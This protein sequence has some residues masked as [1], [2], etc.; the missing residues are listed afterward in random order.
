MIDT[1]TGE[2]WAF[3]FILLAALFS[4]A[5]T[6]LATSDAVRQH[7]R[8]EE[9]A[10][11][12]EADDRR[13]KRQNRR[14]SVER[15]L[16]EA[17]RPRLDQKRFQ[18][19]FWS[20]PLQHI[21]LPALHAAIQSAEQVQEEVGIS[22]EVIDA[23]CQ[24]MHNA[25]QLQAQAALRCG[26]AEVQLNGILES[27]RCLLK[28]DTAALDAALDEAKLAGVPRSLLDRAVETLQRATR[29]QRKRDL[30]LERLQLATAD[31]AVA[32]AATGELEKEL[33]ELKLTTSEMNAIDVGVLTNASEKVLRIDTA[34][35][36]AALLDLTD[37]LV[38]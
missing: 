35:L 5:V 34:E 4:A 7:V 18:R 20:N 23:A 26:L 33:K 27:A 16:Q 1:T 31:P 12:K 30:A 22:V 9:C 38:Y 32:L 11:H 25:A 28:F 36:E 3:V 24:I 10:R 6:C 21:N 17:A 13:R 15:A 2:E 8:P 37:D 14:R 19:F 29:L